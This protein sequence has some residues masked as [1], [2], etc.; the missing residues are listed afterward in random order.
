MTRNLAEDYWVFITSVVYYR[1]D[2]GYWGN[3]ALILGHQSATT[4]SEYYETRK[5]R[6]YDLICIIPGRME[7]KGNGKWCQSSIVVKFCVVLIYKLFFF[8]FF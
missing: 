2:L 4:E 5:I 7:E 1:Y 8:F 3:L 6:D